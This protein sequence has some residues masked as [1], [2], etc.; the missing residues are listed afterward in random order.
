MPDTVELARREGIELVKTG[1]WATMSGSWNPTPED[2]AAA[3]EAQACPAIEKPVIKLGHVDKRFDGEPALG[4][5]E[6][7]RV[8]DNGHTLLGDQV[9]LPWLASVQAAAYPSRSIEGNYNHTCASGHKHKFVLTAVALLGVTPPAVKTI[10]RLNDLPAMLGV[11]AADAEVPEGAEHVQVTI[12]AADEA[13]HTGAMVALI[14]TLEDATRLVVDGG[15]PASELHVTLA[16]LGKAADLGEAGQQDVIDKVSTAAN[17]LPQITADV[18]SVNVFNPGDSQPDRDTC[19]V[20]GLSGEL[21][22]AVHDLISESLW[23]VPIPAQH[24]PWVAHMT[25]A[26]TADLAKIADLAGRMGPV[27]FDRLRLAFARQHVDIPL[28][29]EPEPLDDDPD[30]VAA[31]GG[32]DEQ[33]KRYWL[34]DGLDRW[35]TKKHPWTALYR[36]ILK[37]VKNAD[38]AKRI[39]SDWYREHFGRTPNQKVK[40]S[41]AVP[42]AASTPPTENPPPADPPALVLPAAEPELVNPEPKEEDPVS[43][44]DL[45]VHRSRLGLADDADQDA[46]LTAYAAKLTEAESVK[47]E[48][49]PEMVAASAAAAEKAE[50]AEQEKNELAKEVQVLASQVKTMSDELAASKAEQAATVK[51]SVLDAAVKDG[52]IKPADRAQWETDYDE[53]PAAITRVLASIAPGT[54]VPV[55]ASGTAGDPEPVMA[56]GF[57]DDD[58]NRLFGITQ[59]A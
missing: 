58:Y 31:A 37:K 26:Y 3:V 18:F 30:E 39:A 1:R 5:F 17:G 13:V 25:A 35:A 56:S 2:L 15:E 21:L 32:D 57:S 34:G 7:L 50:K 9:T 6:N 38:K 43:T 33:L 20:Y 46:V 29:G 49:T 10:R 45:S 47:P 22:D 4:Y 19:L 16:Y 23:G 54:A 24:R 28:I 59:E 11:A 42:T 41:D 14:P 27:R 55:M 36:L 51:A 52:K 40:A 53:A 12:L 48:P 8:A 44:T